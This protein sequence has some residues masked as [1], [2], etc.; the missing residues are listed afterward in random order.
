MALVHTENL[1]AKPIELDDTLI[2]PVEKSS[3]IQPPGMWGLLLWRRPVSVIVQ[4]T[5]GSEEII[6]VQ[7]ATRRAQLL[8]IGIGLVGSILI[9]LLNRN[10]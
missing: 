9:W 7:D 2:V 3:R 8:L 1:A 6:P 10:R 4:H 5:N